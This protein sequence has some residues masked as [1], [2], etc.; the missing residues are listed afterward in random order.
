MNNTGLILTNCLSQLSNNASP[1]SFMICGDN[2]S[3]GNRASV[4]TLNMPHNSE[5]F[6][7]VSSFS[8]RK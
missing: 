3:A 7:A 6:S 4:G 5:T 8:S 1:R 2:P